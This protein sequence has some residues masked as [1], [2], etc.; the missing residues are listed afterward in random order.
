[1]KNHYLPVAFKLAGH[2]EIV[3]LLGEDEFEI[4]YLVKD[5][6]M[7]EKLFVLKELFLP[8]YA[9]RNEDNSL[10]I[11]AKSKQIF[12]QTKKDV[13]AEIEL[14]K[15][16]EEKKSP[17]LYGYFEEH[18]T[19]YTIMEF[20]NDSNISSY[21]EIDSENERE[22]EMVVEEVAKEETTVATI[23]PIVEPSTL[24]EEKP[25]STLFL[26]ILIVCVVI[27]LGLAFYGYQMLQEE[28]QRIKEKSEQH[29]VTVIKGS[30]LPHPTLENRDDDKEEKPPVEVAVKE[31]NSSSNGAEY[32]ELTEEDEIESD[33]LAGVP[34]EEIYQTE[35]DLEEIVRNEEE[36][37]VFDEE[38]TF[39]ED[40]FDVPSTIGET[41]NSL[42]G[43][44]IN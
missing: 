29:S 17:E 20:M 40:G 19:L 11:M 22:E 15:T 42:L 12:E 1:M 18:N 27:F 7:G 14:L 31:I 36:A 44:R 26:K 16:T 30:V 21:L 3:E 8:S 34:K 32:I 23:E 37:N 38:D 2:Y 10:N 6:H 35:N 24:E 13:I 5:L 33:V 43:R 25:K 4:L 39:E 28:K 9:S 41:T